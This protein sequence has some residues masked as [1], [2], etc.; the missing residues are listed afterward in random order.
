MINVC[1]FAD[2]ARSGPSLR[3]RSCELK[4]DLNIGSNGFETVRGIA[5]I[6]IP[7]PE[8]AVQS[9]DL[10]VDLFIGNVLRSRFIKY[11]YYDRNENNRG[12][13]LACFPC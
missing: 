6:C 8:V 12:C 11:V 7:P 13:L 3:I 2:D 10:A 4:L 1:V 5:S 9:I